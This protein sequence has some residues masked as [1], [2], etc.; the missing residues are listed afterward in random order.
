MPGGRSLPK[1]AQF[2][3]T[4][5]EKHSTAARIT[6]LAVS[7]IGAVL[8]RQQCVKNDS[9]WLC[10]DTMVS[11]GDSTQVNDLLGEGCS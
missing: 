2:S 5:G 1:Q 9:L 3:E 6:C 4:I 7:A 8:P 10:F 11:I